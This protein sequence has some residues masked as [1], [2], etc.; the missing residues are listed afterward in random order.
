MTLYGTCMDPLQVQ[1]Y[2]N[3][4]CKFNKG[5]I[6]FLVCKNN[7]L[8]LQYPCIRRY[9]SYHRVCSSLRICCC[10]CWSYRNRMWEFYF[11][12][13]ICSCHRTCHFLWT[14]SSR[15]GTFR[16]CV[17]NN[18]SRWN[19]QGPSWLREWRVYRVDP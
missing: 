11:C 4:G 19:E 8:K 13:Q 16:G 18:G 6:I 10:S 3:I 5:C 15:N 12:R 17:L 14:C 7:R 1:H 9:Q 2:Q